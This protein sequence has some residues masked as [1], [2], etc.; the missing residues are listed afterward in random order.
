MLT[1]WLVLN[2]RT[3]REVFEHPLILTTVKNI[4]TLKSSLE[5]FILIIKT[6]KYT[7]L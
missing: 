1:V 6:S 5:F 4:E 7:K 2:T 3:A